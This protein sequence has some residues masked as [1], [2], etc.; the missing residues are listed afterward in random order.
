M[1][2][3]LAHISD[4]AA[5]SEI[6]AHYVLNTA[7]SFDFSPP[8]AEIIASRMQEIQK[9]YPYLVAI[10]EG[11]GLLGYA[12]ARSLKQR[13]AYDWSVETSIYLAKGATASGIG[14]TLWAALEQILRLQG[15]ASVFA[16]IASGHELKGGMSELFHSRKGFREVGRLLGCGFKFNR[17]YDVILM[18]KQLT[19]PG[20]APKPI[21]LINEL[22]QRELEPILK[23][24]DE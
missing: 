23:A 8:S 10:S 2:I 7:I 20:D 12:Y 22:S 4:S 9:R 11:G 16:H 6:Y 21:R 5:I 24:K 3:R 1:Q 19:D 15:I 14:S 13:P 17:W 18:Q